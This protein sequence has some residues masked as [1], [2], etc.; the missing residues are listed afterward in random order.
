MSKV[1][2]LNVVVLDNP[3]P[4]NNPFQFEI[5]FECVDYLNEGKFAALSKDSFSF[6]TLVNKLNDIFT[7]MVMLQEYIPVFF[8]QLRLSMEQHKLWVSAP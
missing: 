8:H 6:P 1:N 4:F 3:S 7:I 2:I 5:T